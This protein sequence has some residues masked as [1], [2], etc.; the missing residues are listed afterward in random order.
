LAKQ[1]AE[2]RAIDRA[3]TI[4][5]GAIH[6][7]HRTP[8]SFENANVFVI[9]ATIAVEITANG[10]IGAIGIITH[11]PAALRDRE[12]RISAA[13][14]DRHAVVTMIVQDLAASLWLD[15]S[16]KATARRVSIGF[17]RFTVRVTRDHRVRESWRAKNRRFDRSTRTLRPLRGPLRI[18]HRLALRIEAVTTAKAR[19]STTTDEPITAL[20]RGCASLTVRGK[21]IETRHALI[22]RP[23]RNELELLGRRAGRRLRRSGFVGL[24]R[25]SNKRCNESDRES[26]GR[27]AA[28]RI[29]GEELRGL[30]QTE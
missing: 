19:I 1:E 11:E 8:L 10:R 3:V 29:H 16:G 5:I 18:T 28:K 6:A 4:E 21:A 22:I 17:A 24:T 23:T 2:V 27:E 30:G 20:A 13:L 12:T 14:S 25:T 9:Y 26:D 7:T 15:T